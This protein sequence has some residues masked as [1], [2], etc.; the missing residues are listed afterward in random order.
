M[1]NSKGQ[2]IADT[3]FIIT[4]EQLNKWI[5]V[6]DSLTKMILSKL[7]YPDMLLENGMS[8][9][10]IISFSVDK[11]GMFNDFRLE[12]YLSELSKDKLMIDIKFF[13][14]NAFGSTLFYSGDFAKQGFIADKKIEK[15]YIPFKFDTID[16]HD[17]R[18]VRK[19]W[20]TFLRKKYHNP[21]NKVE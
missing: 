9:Q 3:T 10:I 21:P 14:E 4:K 16:D 13:T 12:K 20:L 15:F 6:E 7:R 17:I 2:V 5:N 1:Y 19:G 11:N 8:G 18:E